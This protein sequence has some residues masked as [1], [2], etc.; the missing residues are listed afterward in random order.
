MNK[1]LYTMCVFGVVSQVSASHNVADEALSPQG[2]HGATNGGMCNGEVYGNTQPAIEFPPAVKVARLGA[3][4]GTYIVSTIPVSSTTRVED[5]KSELL[6]SLRIPSAHRL[7]WNGV[8]VMRESVSEEDGS[9]ITLATIFKGVGEIPVI[10]II[11]D[12]GR[13]PML[14]PT[15][16]LLEG[17]IS[18]LKSPKGE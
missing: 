2:H 3:D 13:S 8:E 18:P 5:F 17:E 6:S 15:P 12:S 14:T 11:M 1:F 4:G 16:P 10:D 9:L 7:M